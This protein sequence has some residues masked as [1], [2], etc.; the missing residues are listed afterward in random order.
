MFE[1]KTTLGVLALLPFA[2]RALE[3][4]QT[5]AD[6]DGWYMDD[7]H[8]KVPEEGCCQFWHT[9]RSDERHYDDP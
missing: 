5:A 8:L 4:T 7:S 6:L 1:R 2:T 9:G 3:L